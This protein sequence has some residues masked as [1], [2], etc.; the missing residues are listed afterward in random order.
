MMRT[1]TISAIFVLALGLM[2]STEN[3]S[4]AAPMGTAFTH[5]GRL[6][7]GYTSADGLY[8]FR[9]KLFDDPYAGLQ[10]GSMIDINDLNV[11]DGYF[12]VELDFGSGVFY[13]DARWL[14]TTVSHSD[15]SD[16]C[17]LKPRLELTPIPYAI[18]AKTAGGDNDWMVSGD[19]MYAIPS[20]RVS[21]GT[22]LPGPK[23]RI[24]MPDGSSGPSRVGGLTIHDGRNNEGMQLEVLDDPG[25]SRF[26]VDY[27]G[28]VGIGTNNLEAGLHLK[29]IGWPNSFMYLQSNATQDTGFRLYEGDTVKWHIYNW[30]EAGGL[31]ICNS[32]FS[33]DVF[34]AKQGNGNVGIGTTNP[35]EKLE[36]VDDYPVTLRMNNTASDSV[37][38]VTAGDLGN[39]IWSNK[40]FALALPIEDSEILFT[41]GG[42]WRMVFQSSGNVGI[43]MTPTQRLSVNGKIGLTDVP[44]WDGTNDNDLTWDGFVISREGSSRR[45]K[46]NIRPFQEDFRK[47][48][49][50]EAKQY[51]MREG[52]GEPGKQLFGYIAEELE[53]IGLTKLLTYDAEGRP[54]G[55][56]YKKMGIYL[57]E[58]VKEQQKIID[59][60]NSVLAE[61]RTKMERFETVVQKLEAMTAFSGLDAR[62]GGL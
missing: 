16:P 23:L 42:L 54:D 41:F 51:Q 35:T 17:T 60:Q 11:I 8:D 32:D 55:I 58:I 26:V 43:G 36:V 13:G 59:E 3:V 34:F 7:D 1:T 19:N 44:V 29:G 56:K 2:V 53:E 45:Y 18:Y 10:Q 57:I 33:E 52:Y 4:N 25:N 27:E 62:D 39:G 50:L 46:Q 40:D 61:L 14:E 31:R 15:G 20:G 30:S 28:R 38:H 22:T 49:R 37:V 5:Q 12:T 48:L 21:I 47:I 6:M 9:F 24:Q